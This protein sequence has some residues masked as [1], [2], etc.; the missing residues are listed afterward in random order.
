MTIEISELRDWARAAGARGTSYSEWLYGEDE[1]ARETVCALRD[2]GDQ[3]V[4]EAHREGVRAKKVA[5]GWVHLWTTA[6]RDYDYF[7]TEE[8]EQSGE[9]CGKALRR[10]L[11]HPHYADYQEGRYGS[12]LHFSGREDPRVEEARRAARL[13]AEARDRA[14]AEGRRAGGLFWLRELPDADLDSEDEDAL[15]ALLR[16]RGCGWPDVRA[17]RKRRAEA[18]AAAARAAQWA[19][20]RAL[21]EDGV[22]LVDEGSPGEHGRYVWIRGR[23]AAVYANAC[24]KQHY[25]LRHHNDAEQAEVAVFEGG[26]AVEYLGSLAVVAARVE[27]GELRL[28]REGE[29]FPPRAVLERLGVPWKEVHRVEL[30]GPTSAVR[31]DRGAVEV[32]RSARV[33]WVGRARPSFE[34]VVLDG[35]GHLVRKRAHVE[36]ARRVLRERETGCAKVAAPPTSAAEVALLRELQAASRGDP[37]ALAALYRSRLAEVEALEKRGLWFALSATQGN[38]TEAGATAL[39]AAKGAP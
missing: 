37:L 23:D 39:R 10:V 29:V 27:R 26:R 6:P 19:R 33:L 18:R 8:V 13:A 31:D 7:G 17:E 14:A 9:W 35:R 16:E 11:A 22:T 24:V 28:A 20:C 1:A 21:F 12:G 25:D 38:L 36:E 5:D 30:E 34:P 15:D 2:A 4:E 3:S 32:T